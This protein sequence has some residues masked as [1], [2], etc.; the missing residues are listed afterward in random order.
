MSD[1]VHRL[2]PADEPDDSI[3]KLLVDPATG[4]AFDLDGYVQNL[5]DE[6]AGSERDCAGWRIRCA[7]LRRDKEAE[8]EESTLWPLCLRVFNYWRTTCRHERS[9]FSLDRF[10]I[11]ETVL[12]PHARTGKKIDPKKLADVEALARRAI[13]GAAFDPYV[14]TRKNG[15]SKRHDG[16]DLIFRN[17]DKFEEFANRAPRDDDDAAGAAAG[18]LPPAPSGPVAGQQRLG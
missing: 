12:L 2:R 18:G 4:Q 3:P 11:M 7:E 1:N 6:L 14:T 9:S 13:D 15:S 5:R 16:I 10:Q 8:A 17:A